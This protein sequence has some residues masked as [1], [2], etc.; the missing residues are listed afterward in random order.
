MSDREGE[1]PPKARIPEGVRLYVI[2]DIHGRADLLRRIAARIDT[3]ARSAAVQISTIF[4]GDYVDRGPR[5]KEVIELVLGGGFPNVIALKG[6]HEAML[7]SFLRDPGAGPI[8]LD[9]GGWHTLASYGIL[10][11]Q[12]SLDEIRGEFER[13]LPPRH[14]AFLRSLRLSC[15]C[16]DYFFCHAGV[17]PGIA[18]DRQSEADLTW[19]R[20]EFLG[21]DLDH[22]AV[23]VHGHSPVREVETKANRINLDTGAFSSGRLSCLVLQGSERSLIQT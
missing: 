22:G 12:G 11:R 10:P 23:V 15:R 9:N 16:G 20:E 2:G 19:I 18:F 13:R 1:T 3:D 8:W 5:S 4:L 6:N 21:S 7:L 17:R 14:L